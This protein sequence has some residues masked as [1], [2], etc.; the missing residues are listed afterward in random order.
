MYILLGIAIFIAL[1]L[2]LRINLHIIYEDELKVYLKILFF[3]IEILPNTSKIFTSNKSGKGK[4]EKPTHILKDISEAD[5]EKKSILDKLNTIRDILSILSNAFH[6]HLHI[7]LSKIMVKVATGDAAKTAI[8]YGAIST[9]VAC[10]IDIID[11]IANLK[12]MKESSVSVEPDFLSEKTSLALNIHL[13]MSV[14]GM[15]KVLIQ[16]LIKYYVL[17]D[18]SQL[19]SRKEN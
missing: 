12:P 10:I 9:A 1:I 13:Y 8:L 6:K 3:K 16:S 5:T 4:K 11:N 19:Q 18:K 17:N 15:I 14:G 7:R 2:S